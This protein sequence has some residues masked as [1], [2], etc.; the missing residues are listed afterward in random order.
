MSETLN[1]PSVKDQVTNLR[2]QHTELAQEQYEAESGMHFARM[3]SANSRR[4]EAGRRTRGNYDP[5]GHFSRI[6][7]ETHDVTAMAE[8]VH[9]EAVDAVEA[10]SAEAAGYVAQNIGE[11]VTQA[12]QEAEAQGVEINSKHL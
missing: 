12:A 4:S 3:Q 7:T 1:Q 5:T 6:A 8:Q 11:I 9:S 2:Q 10:Q